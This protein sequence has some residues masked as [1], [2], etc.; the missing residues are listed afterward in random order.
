MVW[1]VVTGIVSWTLKDP[2]VSASRDIQVRHGFLTLNI[3][4]YLQEHEFE[5]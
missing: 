3:Y 2:D 5:H 1:T 4:A